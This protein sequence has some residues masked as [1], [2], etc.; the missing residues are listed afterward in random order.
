M[1]LII[2][3]YKKPFRIM[4]SIQELTIEKLEIEDDNM[5]EILDLLKKTGLL[6]VYWFRKKDV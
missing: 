3:N 2:E 1:K 4:D 5:G 6:E